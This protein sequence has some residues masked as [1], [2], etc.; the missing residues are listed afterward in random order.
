MGGGGDHGFQ[1]TG[2]DRKVFLGCEIFD[3]GIFWEGEYLQTFSRVA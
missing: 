3:T 1:V 2:T